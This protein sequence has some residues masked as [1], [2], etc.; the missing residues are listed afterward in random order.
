MN[1]FICLLLTLSINACSSISDE[2]TAPLKVNLLGTWNYQVA[3]E[4][5]ICDDLVAQGIWT[6]NSAN[7][8]VSLI[9]DIHIQ[10]E[11][12]SDDGFGNCIYVNIDKMITVLDDAPSTVTLEKLQ[13]DFDADSAKD[14]AVTSQTVTIFTETVITTTLT[15]TNGIIRTTTLTR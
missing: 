4:N 15:A 9:G 10:G 6:Y 13:E 5:S 11:D 8:D 3:L 12:F 2:T 1:K 7:G 14:N